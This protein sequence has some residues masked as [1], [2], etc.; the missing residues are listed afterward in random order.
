MGCVRAWVEDSPYTAAL[1]VRVEALSQDSA[2]LLLPYQD[3]N[4][5]PGRALHGGCAAS[6]AA[7]GAQAVARL[8]LGERSGPWHSAGLQ[9]NYLSAAIG[10]D[11]IAE[12]RLLRRGKA[13]CFVEA[14]VATREGRALAHA[15]T[16]VRARFGADPARLVS[17]QGDDGACQPGPLGPHIEQVPFMR[18]L[19][20]RVEH[21]A[22]GRSRLR[23]PDAPS[24]S[25]ASG[26]VHEGALL[27]LVDTTGAMACWAETGPG[28]YKAS[29]PALQAQ[30]LAPPAPGDLVA[31]AR[32]VQR[33]GELFWSDVEVAGAADGALRA[34]GTVIYRIVT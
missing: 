29:T 1:G 34:R 13:I 19:G 9:V 10:E 31:Y 16:S 20:I 14:N 28:R 25:D 17:V 21:M 4:S 27:A 18:K 26:G 2:R 22:G 12:A 32:L 8:A 3:A 6:L 15:T 5:N 24:N 7:V 11:V 23:L 30:I 33:D